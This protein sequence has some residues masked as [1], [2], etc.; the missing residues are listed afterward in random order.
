MPQ[1]HPTNPPQVCANSPL[2]VPTSSSICGASTSSLNESAEKSELHNLSRNLRNHSISVVL[3][4]VDRWEGAMVLGS[5][6]IKT[7]PF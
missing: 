1:D 4:E 7:I 2:P 3:P 5:R 6:K